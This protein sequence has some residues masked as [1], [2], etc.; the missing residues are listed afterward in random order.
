MLSTLNLIKTNKL[1]LAS[2]AFMAVFAFGT[3][4]AHAATLNVSGGCTLDEA[5]TSVNNGAA[6][7]GC[8]VGGYGTNDTINIPA[9]TVTLTAD[10][11]QIT[12]PVT[13]AG[14]GMEDT[15]V[16]GDA[17]QYKLFTS[18]TNQITIAIHDLTLTAYKDFA[19]WARG[20]SFELS[21][22]EVDGNDVMTTGNDVFAVFLGNVSTFNNTVIA[23][24]IYIHNFDLSTGAGKFIDG[25]AVDQGGGATTTATLTN[26]TISDL[27]NGDGGIAGFV[28]SVGGFGGSGGGTMNASVTN[29]TIHDIT[30]AEGVYAFGSL[31]ITG[32][33]PASVNNAITNV[34]VTGVR[35]SVGILGQLS[36]AI[37]SAGISFV[38]GQATINTSIQNSLLAD[39]LSDGTPNNCLAGNFNDEFGGVGPVNATI[40]SLGH[41]LA[42]DA[43]CTSF[44][45]TG[46]RQNVSNIISTLGPLQDNGG[47]VPTR[48]L[49]PGS[50]A[51]NS[52]GSVLGVTTDARGVARNSC[53][54]VGAFQ[55]EGA[56]CAATTTNA[57]AGGVAA[58]NT[59][60]KTASTLIAFVSSTLGLS[61]IAY[62]FRKRVA[63]K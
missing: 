20:P 1:I 44:T 50:P 17:G 45:Q 19:V 33:D 62:A 52:G 13:I 63:V 12:A 27:H 9:G 10:L 22:I 11:P 21:D 57:N 30:G 15:I 6:E 29:T 38:S 25:F 23:H 53:P 24:N 48:A 7:P 61:M 5:I 42:D 55:F 32:T 31:G 28:V 26:T 18:E 3:G 40:A 16:S 58:P 8:T 41:N 60:A 43:N 59:G 54:S 47:N 34:T 36:T 56:V 4:R 46:D 37:F 51:I 2:F 14:A 35:G 49:L 39:N